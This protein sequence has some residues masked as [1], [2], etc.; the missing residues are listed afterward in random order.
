MGKEPPFAEAFGLAPNWSRRK[1]PSYIATIRVVE[2][3]T[4]RGKIYF[5]FTCSYLSGTARFRCCH[6]PRPPP[7][8]CLPCR[9]GALPSLPSSRTS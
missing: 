2:K 3:F 1:L 7:E 8:R 5:S 4:L 6:T 9:G